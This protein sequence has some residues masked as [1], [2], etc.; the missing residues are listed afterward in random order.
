MWLWTRQEAKQIDELSIRSGMDPETLMETA[1]QASAAKIMSL[2][3]STRTAIVLCG[4]GHNGGDGFV[5]ARELLRL[6]IQVQVVDLGGSSP[7]RQKKKNEFS[8]KL[9]QPEEFLSRSFQ[10][11]VY[12]D[13]LFGIGLNRTL[14]GPAFS[15]VEKVNQDQGLKVSLDTPSGLDVDTGNILGT[16]F[17]AHWTLTVGNPKPGFYLNEGPGV[18]GKIRKI[19]AGFALSISSRI[20]HSVYLLHGELVQ[21]WIPIRNPTDNKSQGGRAL[22]WAGSSRMPGAA[23][24]AC[25]AA[26]RVGSG[27]VYCSESKVIQYRPEILPWQHGDFEKISSILLGPGLGIG[28]ST[29][30]A[31]EEVYKRNVPS[32]IDAD[33]L[34]VASQTDFLPFPKRWISTPH[35]GELARLLQISSDEI[36]KD[37]LLAGRKAQERISGVILIKGFHTVVAY[38]KFSVIVPKGNIALAKAG[39]GDVLAGMIAG[40]L[41][42]G[43]SIE[44]APLLAAY[45]HGWIADR[46]ISDGNDILSLTPQDILNRIPFSLASIRKD[47]LKSGSKVQRRQSK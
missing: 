26:T 9:L 14:E 35:A 8:G 21:K 44:R 38:P 20:A 15:I 45:I 29:L 19:E 46:W 13:A 30:H 28:N 39:S 1:G 32:I 25:E 18:C 2:A 3:P 42:Q 6:G 47:K 40:F 41:S 31:L 7:L 16:C 24:L 27:Y 17:H 5:V 22:I 36:E 4:P 12:I 11:D 10:S 33:A 23:L 37:R 34:T 43:V